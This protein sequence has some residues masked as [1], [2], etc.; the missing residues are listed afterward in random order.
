MKK[1]IALGFA[2][3][4]IVTSAAFADKAGYTGKTMTKEEY[5]KNAEK[6]FDRIDA[7]KDGKITPEE[8]RAYWKEKKLEHQH[9]KEMHEKLHQNKKS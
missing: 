3:M 2:V 9:K 1:I 4:L 8:R 7:N 6:I 5:I